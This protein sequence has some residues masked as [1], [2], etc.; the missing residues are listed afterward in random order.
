MNELALANRQPSPD[1]RSRRGVVPQDPPARVDSAS[2]VPDRMP[3]Q[4]RPGQDTLLRTD[5]SSRL[6]DLARPTES[7]EPRDPLRDLLA[8]Q[9]QQLTILA[10]LNGN[11]GALRQLEQ[12]A[13]AIDGATTPAQI[14][15]M[16]RDIGPIQTQLI[17]Q[18]QEAM[19][20]MSAAAIKAA[21]R[22]QI[23]LEIENARRNLALVL[24]HLDAR[25]VEM[26]GL[27]VQLRAQ[28]DRSA[29]EHLTRLGITRDPD[30][31]EP[32][33]NMGASSVPLS[34]GQ[35]FLSLG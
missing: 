23:D 16:I 18:S 31:A 10:R 2:R 21:A 6:T 29:L 11:R 4:R 8:Q 12:I 7:H 5:L 26:A 34:S 30:V 13:R 19:A 24:D 9:V 25:S 27:L 1:A 33:V 22:K 35:R 32:G 17:S 28:G 14:D 15:A 3:V 20:E